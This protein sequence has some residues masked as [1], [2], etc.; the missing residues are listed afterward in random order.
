MAKAIK[1]IKSIQKIIDLFVVTLDARAP[2]STYNPSLERIA[3]QKPRLFIITK[4][5]L[6]DQKKYDYIRSQLESE[7][8][9]VLFLNLKNHNSRKAV[10]SAITEILGPKI[11]RDKER[12]LLRSRLKV[13]VIG[14]PNSGKSTLINLL[15]K[16]KKANVKNEPGVTRSQQWF[17]VGEFNVMDTPGVLWPKLDNQKIATKLA[18]IGSIK[19]DI[20]PKKD[21]FTNAYRLISKYYPDK[22]I[23]LGLEPQ[24]KESEIFNELIK[25]CRK[26]NYMNNNKII[27]QKGI[28]IFIKNVVKMNSITLD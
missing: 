28:D 24:K 20:L 26:N 23:A 21:V 27:E 15:N 3:P 16:K 25:Y 9:K 6:G 5:D 2:L 18:I 17:N 11:K 14:V 19:F 7:E 1:E 8:S 12:G 13:M 10:S 4:I 22:I